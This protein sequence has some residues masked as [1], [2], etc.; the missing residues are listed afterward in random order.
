MFSMSTSLHGRVKMPSS[1]H[2]W[3]AESSSNDLKNL[4]IERKRSATKM[5]QAWMDIS[6][7]FTWAMSKT[8]GIDPILE[9]N[10]WRALVAIMF[11][12]LFFS[13][14]GASKFETIYQQTIEF[15]N[16]FLLWFLV[17]WLRVKVDFFFSFQKKTLWKGGKTLK[18]VRI[19]TVVDQ[20]AWIQS[21][22]RC[23]RERENSP[24]GWVCRG[25][26]PEFSMVSMAFLTDSSKGK[27][28]T[29]GVNK[30]RHP[31]MTKMESPK[32]IRQVTPMMRYGYT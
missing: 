20:Q 30:R 13:E 24:L 18:N 16:L 27:R 28:W 9:Q 21:F 11:G 26:S 22:N 10:S 14:F 8:E 15:L 25:S 6:C 3:V 29:G 7:S 23:M 17:G 2:S 4:V 5:I 12:L 32:W 1:H 19:S 31:K